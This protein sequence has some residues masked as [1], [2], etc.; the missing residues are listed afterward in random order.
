M[1]H[2]HLVDFVQPFG[3]LGFTH[4]TSSPVL[5]GVVQKFHH[6]KSDEKG[7]I[8]FVSACKKYILI[9]VHLIKG[10]VIKLYL[11]LAKLMVTVSRYR[12]SH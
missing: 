9:S 3:Y 4:W 11:L 12:C 6:T 5:F 2:C 1:L 7:Y 8:L 10:G